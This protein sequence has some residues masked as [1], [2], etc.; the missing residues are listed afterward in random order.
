MDN[1]CRI[2]V[3]SDNSLILK[4][5]YDRFDFELQ[6]IGVFD[7]VSTND[8]SLGTLAALRVSEKLSNSNTNFC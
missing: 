5:L 1:R 2:D 3:D 4:P 8:F 6:P 7:E